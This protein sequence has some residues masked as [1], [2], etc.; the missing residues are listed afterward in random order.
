MKHCKV[1]KGQ[2]VEPNTSVCNCGGDV[3]SGKKSK[4]NTDGFCMNS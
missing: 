3:Q 1:I 4:S 2:G